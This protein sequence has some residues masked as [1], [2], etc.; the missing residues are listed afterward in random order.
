MSMT[1]MAVSTR[2]EDGWYIA[3]CKE[4][5]RVVTQGRTLSQVRSRFSEALG[6]HLE[7]LAEPRAK[8]GRPSKNQVVIGTFQ[9][10][11]SATSV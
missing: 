2:D 3:Q 6:G 1:F 8:H 10:E 5:P 7:A 9:Y 4:L 11:V